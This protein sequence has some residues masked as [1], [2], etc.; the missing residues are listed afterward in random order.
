MDLN[1]IS[2]HLLAHPGMTAKNISKKVG[3]EPRLVKLYFN[4]LIKQR[5]AYTKGKGDDAKYYSKVKV[6]EE[7]KDQDHDLIETSPEGMILP[8]RFEPDKRLSKLYN[9]Q[10]LKKDLVFVPYAYFRTNKR[11][12]LIVNLSTGKTEEKR[13]RLKI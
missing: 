12:E 6:P 13:I 7:L 8:H 11:K 10:I 3:I 2:L 1:P 4:K 9:I 5:L